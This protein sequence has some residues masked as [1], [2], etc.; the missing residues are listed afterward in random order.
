M[1]EAARGFRLHPTSIVEVYTVFYNL[2]ICCEWTY[3]C[4]PYTVIPVQ[5]G[6]NF[7]KNWGMC[8][9]KRRWGVID[10][11]ARGFRLH[12]TSMLDVYK[13]FEH[14][15]MLCMSIWVHLYTVTPA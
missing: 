14:L 1:V 5:V 4:T 8:K 3:G 7:L 11:T 6:A 13:V 2:S 10:E 12:P 9:P 15:D